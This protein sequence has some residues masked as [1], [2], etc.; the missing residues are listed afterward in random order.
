MAVPTYDKF[1]LPLLTLTADQKEHH[2]AEDREII[3]NKVLRLS[4]E[5]KRVL[6]PSGR[7]TNYENRLYWARTYLTK[8]GLLETTGRG[9]YKITERGLAVLKEPPKAINSAYLMQF[10]EFVKFQRATDQTTDTKSLKIDQKRTPEEILDDAYSE[11]R[12]QLAQDILT[13]V[14]ACDPTFFEKLVVDLLV[15]MGYGGSHKDA[16]TAIG[17]SGDGGIDGIIK[18][19]KLGLDAIFIQ[20]KKWENSVGRPVVQA[21]AGSLEGQRAKKG[22]LITTSHF[23]QDAKEYVNR[24]EKKIVLI[25]GENLAQLMIDHGIAVNEVARY[26]IKKIDWDYFGDSE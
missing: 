25:D 13:R 19:D 3:A 8:A 21:F 4:E 12:L 22:I 5:D 17:R 10:P 26:E 1:M 9:K 23:T 18:E 6:L 14:K 24:I 16:G 20:A 2:I 7:Q 11:L 15:K